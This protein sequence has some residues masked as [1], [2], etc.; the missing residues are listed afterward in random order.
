MLANGRRKSTMVGRIRIGDRVAIK[1]GKNKGDPVPRKADQF[2]LTSNNALVLEAASRIYGGQVQDWII[3]K[4]WQGKGTAPDHKYR[5]YTTSDLLK[6]VFRPARVMD[7]TREQWDGGWCVRRC[8][9]AHILFDAYDRTKHG[10]ACLCPADD[11]E[12]TQLAKTKGGKACLEISRIE[13]QIWDLPYGYWRVDTKGTNGPAEIRDLQDFL[14][15]VGMMHRPLEAFLRLEQS[16]SRV[17]ERNRD[18][19][20]EK[21]THKYG[22]VV[23]EPIYTAAQLAQLAAPPPRLLLSEAASAAV[24]A[25]DLYG[26][27]A[28]D[29]FRVTAPTPRSPMPPRLQEL[30]AQHDVEQAPFLAWCARQLHAT[31]PEAFTNEDWQFALTAAERQAALR[32]TPRKESQGPTPA[33]VAGYAM[34]T[35][36]A[37]AEDPLVP[38]AMRARIAD[39]LAP[40]LVAATEKE[41]TTLA[42][43]ILAYLDTL[44]EEA[45]TG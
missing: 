20:P 22:R 1:E 15:E 17:I 36:R 30:L 44:Q 26:D 33:D 3:P 13:V 37:H 16:T 2:I 4:E 40:G 10:T 8:D 35:L 18:G 29:V 19:E 32:A 42:S 21:K 34:V 9:G 23:I 11:Y 14:A 41:A 24:A 38:E 7:T 12:R 5:L 6:V 25:D 31:S 45:A 39:L 43:A 28:G 27:H